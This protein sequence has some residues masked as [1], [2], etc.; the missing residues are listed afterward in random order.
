M[1]LPELQSLR[2]IACAYQNDF[3]KNYY[4]IVTNEKYD[5]NVSLKVNI[6]NIYESF[7]INYVDLFQFMRAER[8]NI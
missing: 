1:N 7:S 6:P 2:L 4:F 5:V 3:Y 8:I